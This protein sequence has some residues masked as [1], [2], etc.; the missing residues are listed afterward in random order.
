MQL[1]FQRQAGA[2]LVEIIMVV[3]LISIITVGALNYFNSASESSRVQE[4][5]SNL[6]SISSVIRNQFAT[7]GDYDGL[8]EEMLSRS[9]NLPST[10]KSTTANHLRHPW[11]SQATAVTIAPSTGNG[12][13]V[14]TYV[15]IPSGACV[16]L[17]SKT[18]K[19]FETIDIGTTA[20][21]PDMSGPA[22]SI[23]T[24]CS[25]SDP[26]TIAFTQS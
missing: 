24:A 18:F 19:N 1:H 10:L 23:S 20:I 12:S 2:T 17:V 25:A 26:V 22:A 13:F 11:G 5:V 15:G 14:L 4:G 16:D 6:T 3:A 21:T 8:T 9:S 7:Q